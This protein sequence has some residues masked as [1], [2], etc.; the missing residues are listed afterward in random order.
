ML[1]LTLM[2]TGY[3]VDLP[4]AA[5]RHAELRSAATVIGSGGCYQVVVDIEPVKQ[6]PAKQH[7]FV[8][9]DI[10]ITGTL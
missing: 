4:T 7:R 9:D 2:D 8:A 10:T 6:R 1:R 3:E 5:G